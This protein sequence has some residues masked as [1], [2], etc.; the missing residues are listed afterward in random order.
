MAKSLVTD[1]APAAFGPYSQG[2]DTGGLVF[3]SGQLG[4]D[5]KTGEMPESCADQARLVMK[6]LAA[7]LAAAGCT[8]DNVVKTTIFLADINDFSVVND[9]YGACFTRTKPARSTFQVAALPKGGK[10]E[11]EAIAAK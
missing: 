5:P 9:I 7:V 1:D 2:I 4:V 6:N 8:Y 10:V 3:V 11:I